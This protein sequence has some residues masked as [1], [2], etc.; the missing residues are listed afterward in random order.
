MGRMLVNNRLH[1]A[2]VWIVHVGIIHCRL[3][4]LIDWTCFREKLLPYLHSLLQIYIV[5]AQIFSLHTITSGIQSAWPT[6]KVFGQVPTNMNSNRQKQVSGNRLT[7]VM[8]MTIFTSMIKHRKISS[9][10]FSKMEVNIVIF[11]TTVNLFPDTC[12]YLLL[13]MEELQRVRN[14]E[15]YFTYCSWIGKICIFVT[16]YNGDGV[17][18][19]FT[20][21]SD[22]PLD[23]EI[24]PQYK[25]AH[26][27]IQLCKQTFGGYSLLLLQ[28]VYAYFYVM[29]ESKYKEPIHNT[30]GNRKSKSNHST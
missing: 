6:G 25:S 8:K 24:Q 5:P 13:F 2:C 18:G 9:V 30:N 10:S 23:I 15:K 27:T 11:I 7:V 22:T 29:H 28:N 20:V 21:P 17:Y 3:C 1:P 12:F 14:T 26:S 4:N 16:V 19:F